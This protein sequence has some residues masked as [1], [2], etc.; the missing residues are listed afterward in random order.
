[1]SDL[2][3]TTPIAF[4]AR[5]L[6]DGGTGDSTYM[7]DLIST[8]ARLYPQQKQLLFAAAPGQTRDSLAQE[9]PNVESTVLPYKIGWLWNQNALV[10]HL[11]KTGVRL[12]HSQYL[13]PRR[14]RGRMVVTIHDVS[15][16]EH[17]E[18]FPKRPR[19]I[20]NL[21]IPR[22]ARRA[23]VIIT[24]SEY[25][26]QAIARTCGVPLEKI[27]VT[28][29]AAASW[30]KPATQEQGEAIAQK[31]QLQAPFLLGIGLR[32]VRKN[33]IVVLQAL[34]QLRQRQEFAG[35][36]LALTGSPEQFSDEIA[37][38]PAVQFLGWVPAEDLP[39]LYA[40]ATVAVY[41][42]FYEGFGLPVLEAMACGCPMICSNT[43]SIPEVAGD[44]AI[45]IAPHDVEGWAKAI[46]QTVSDKAKRQT[47]IETGQQRA[48]L[49]SWEK[50]VR[51]TMAI[52]RQLD[53]KIVL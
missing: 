34:E 26:R 14:F 2:S 8:M 37:S 44:A 39:P 36:K 53:D 17:P 18:W 19:V 3:N 29:Y 50:T 40:A 15:F 28:P 21:L 22:A 1:M 30:A 43:T 31:Y 11:E 46:E 12:L 45:Q 27:K 24:G 49:F 13:L 16:R 38:H 23:D 9:F 25:S 33:P 32:G 41:P 6:L 48:S 42:S 35:F 4:D 51:E 20:M 10:P 7:R 47:M 5:S 52:Y